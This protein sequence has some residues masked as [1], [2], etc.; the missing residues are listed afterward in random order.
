MA[1]NTT[2]SAFRFGRVTLAPGV[3]TAI[4]PPRWSSGVMV[5]VV[6][7]GGDTKVYSSSDTTQNEYRTVA[8]GYEWVLTLDVKAF[9]PNEVAF[10]LQSVAGADI[11]LT[12]Y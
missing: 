1:G 3:L 2:S 10:W 4:T 8:A 7:G 5:G 12:W 9:S 6:A 11:V